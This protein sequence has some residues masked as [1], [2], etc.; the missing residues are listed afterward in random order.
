[1]RLFFIA[2]LAL[3]LVVSCNNTNTA[4][5]IVTYKTVPQGSVPD[6]N[7]DSFLNGNY[8]GAID[9]KHPVLD[10]LLALQRLYI[11][12]KEKFKPDRYRHFWEEFRKESVNRDLSQEEVLAWVDL[13]GFLFQ[14]T[15]DPIVAEELERIA[16]QYFYN[17]ENELADSLILPY[18]FTRHTDNVHVN[19]FLP[20]SIEFEHSLGGHVTITQNSNFP[21]SGEILIV[22]GMETKQ[23]IELYVRIPSWS[24][25]TEVSVKGVKY[26]AHP[27]SYTKIAKKWKE[28]DEVEV[29]IRMNNLPRHLAPGQ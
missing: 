20:A 18:V 2:G 9:G 28:G 21:Q 29:S 15:A 7:V 12:E 11:A 16:W 23:Y 24:N 5:E 17:N 10:S 25:N 4:P 1:M 3:L 22:F 14:L 8:A 19:L 26:L 6:D 13:T 27:G